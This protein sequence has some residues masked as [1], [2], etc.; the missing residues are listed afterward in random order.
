MKTDPFELF[1]LWYLPVVSSGKENSN[2]VI[3]SSS[4]LNGRVSSRVIL[5]KHYDN[6]GFV[7]F[8]NYNSTKGTQLGENPRASLLFYWPDSARQIRIEG[9]VEKTGGAESDNYFNSRNH[10]HKVNAIISEQSRPIENISHFKQ[11]LAAAS[12]FYKDHTPER[13]ASWGGF[14]L[15]P[16]RFEFWEEGENRFHTRQEFL[17]DG[18]RWISRM[19]YP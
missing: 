19:L 10:G 11:K 14:R 1:N 4:S 12:E 5:L 3:L 18:D 13:P 9:M 8:T 7:F 17:Y 2:A 16:D 15:I 6:E